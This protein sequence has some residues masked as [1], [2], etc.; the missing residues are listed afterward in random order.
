MKIS[1]IDA[2]HL[3]EI[4]EI[5][6]EIVGVWDLTRG[7]K[8][9]VR[10]DSGAAPV[11]VWDS[12][13]AAIPSV[14]RLRAGA[15]LTLSGRVSEYK[16]ELRVAPTDGSDIQLKQEVDDRRRVATRL[17]DLPDVGAGCS[18]WVTGAITARQAFSKGFKLRITDGSGDAT[19]LL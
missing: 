19:V 17:A 1:D 3:G 15:R 14:N 12:V 5:A 16:S 13:L 6:G 7:R 18:V 2:S 8:Y 9:Q 10:D 4:V 11:I